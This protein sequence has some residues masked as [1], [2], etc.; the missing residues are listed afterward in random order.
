MKHPVKI[1]VNA[2]LAGNPVKLGNYTYMVGETPEGKDVLCFRAW[3]EPGQEEVLLACDMTV[4][5]FFRECEK[6]S[7]DELFLIGCSKVL[8]ELNRKK[9]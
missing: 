9:R 6:L 7:E 1:V 2:L 4:N 5:A 8:S 3:K